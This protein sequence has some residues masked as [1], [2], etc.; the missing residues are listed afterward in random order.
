MK[1]KYNF[2]KGDVVKC[3]DVGANDLIEGGLYEVVLDLE[4]DYKEDLLQVKCVKTGL[5]KEAFV[6]RF[7]HVKTT[8]NH[9]ETLR[10]AELESIE[11][12]IVNEISRYEKEIREGLLYQHDLFLKYGRDADIDWINSEDIVNAQSNKMKLDKKLKEVQGDIQSLRHNILL[13]VISC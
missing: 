8:D 5:T 1:Y 10:L 2:K 13:D 6:R 12:A 9:S 7:E 3:V 4:T 11:R